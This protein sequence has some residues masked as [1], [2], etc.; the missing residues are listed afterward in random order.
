MHS[1][2]HGVDDMV[3][4]S[5]ISESAIN[6]NL[7][8]RYN[9]D[10]IYT[11]IGHVLISVN[12]FKEIKGL[13]LDRTLKDYKGKYRYELPPHVYATADDMY[14]SML[15]ERENQCVIISGESGAG[16]TEASKKIMQFVA[17]VSGSSP[18]VQHVKDVILESNPLLEAF[19]NAKTI[20]NNNSS[21][22]GKYMEIQFAITGDPEGGRINNYLLE[23][24]RVIFQTPSERN[25]HVFYQLLAGADSAMQSELGITGPDY[26][27]YLNQGKCYTVEGMDDTREFRDTVQAMNTIGIS[28]SEQYDIWRVVMGILYL[29]NVWFNPTGKDGA[30][31]ADKQVVEMFAHLIQS[32][33]ASCSKS[34]CFRTISTGTQGRSAR[35][36]TYAC[37]QNV[38]GAVY[39]R[40]ALAKALYS[41]MFD[42]I[43]AR[44]NI[45]LGWANDSQYISLGILDIY[46]FEIFEANG[47]EQFCINYVNEK[48]QQIFIQLTLKAEQEEYANEGIQWEHI[49]F[50]NNKICCDLVELKKPPGLIALLDDTCNFPKGT[51]DKFLQKAMESFPDHPHFQGHMVNN[52]FTIR[53]YAG[54]VLYSVDGFCDKNKDLLFNDLI[55]LAHCTNSAFV[56]S[57]FPEA[58]TAA[59][60]RRPTTAGTKI[61]DSINT[62]VAALE[63]C[64]PHYI[65]CIKPNDKKQPN[66]FANALCEHQV[67][68]LGLLENVRVRRAGYAYR[69]FYDKFF[70]R[71]RVCSSETWPNWSG[72]FV[73][74]SEAI[75]RVLGL[76]IGQYQKGKTKIF[77]RAPETVFE[78]EGLRER[79][80]YSYANQIQRFF[81]RFSL[82]N[83][84]YNIQMNGNQKLQGHKERR[85]ESIERPFK[86]DYIGYRENFPLKA[87]VERNGKEKVSFADRVNKYD[88]RMKA[89]R[90]VLLLSD[91]ALYIIAI[92]KNPDKD[93]VAKAKKPWIYVEKRRVEHNRVKGI[94]MS[95]LSDNFFVIHVPGD[96]DSLCEN[97]RKTEFM[98]TFLK[99]VPSLSVS[100]SDNI[101]LVIKGG[102]SQSVQFAHDPSAGIG[103]AKGKKVVVAPGL[104]KSTVPNIPAPAAVPTVQTD[105]YSGLNR[106]GASR[107]AARGGAAPSRGAPSFGG[108]GGFGGGSSGGP[109]CKAL[110]EFEAANPDELTFA[111]GAI[112]DIVEKQG[113]WWQGTLNGQTG[114]FPASYV[115]EIP[116]GGGGAPRGG[117]GAPMGAPRG[118]PTR[119]APRGA[120]RGGPGPARG[121]PRGGPPR[122]GPGPARG[123]PPRGA[124]RGRGF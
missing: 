122:G 15:S 71:Y 2:K 112:I 102:K 18:A 13:Y 36:S 43:I 11:Y 117:R 114:L 47:F 100:F 82:S 1:S 109:K 21:R 40:D 28:Q 76:Q 70:Y 99:Y 49:D 92:E 27:H 111:A 3:M 33:V 101:S 73:S 113:E 53:H 5:S 115:E 38:E 55:D 37:P 81:L 89:Q 64:Q 26:F 95:S 6:E 23:K 51:D 86:G 30:E 44:I 17:A 97:R 16:K 66:N 106:G 124:P 54:D 83:Y 45:A 69:Q 10:V 103:K 118:G 120:P 20:R 94:T 65:R 41:R 116:G 79:K 22:F 31:V 96:Y 67:K 58:K 110:F 52:Q 72:D 19:G 59:D 12:P 91:Q 60:K 84:Y 35:V 7:K 107:G 78:L 85:R 98:A 32:D 42:W 105:P 24:S 119:G 48:L 9:N 62:L 80:V 46:G 57:L 93:K 34:L 88:R 90:R 4:L 8:K 104:P 14:R 121:A 63:K 68:Y 56:Q 123:G 75:L 74:G 39:S 87:I 77:V 50:F 61:K 29:G 108:G 25:F